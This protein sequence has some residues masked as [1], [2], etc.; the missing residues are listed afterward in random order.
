MCQILGEKGRHTPCP[1]SL[2]APLLWLPGRQP[3]NV[4]QCLP[5]PLP[6]RALP[7]FVSVK[8]R[9]L[10]NDSLEI[11]GQFLPDASEASRF[12]LDPV[13]LDRGARRP[14][15]R[16]KGFLPAPRRPGPPAASPPPPGSGGLSVPPWWRENGRRPAMPAG[17]RGPWPRAPPPR[18]LHGR[19]PGRGGRRPGRG[20]QEGAA[21]PSA[22]NDTWGSRTAVAVQIRWQV[23]ATDV[24]NICGE[25]ITH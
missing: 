10:G 19:P 23:T 22:A 3:V 21:F 5:K 15:R 20:Q 7:S 16:Q 24:P 25:L 17:A 8:T 2:P 6:R 4:P 9:S 11:G 12:P 14:G 13:Q 18:S 1:T